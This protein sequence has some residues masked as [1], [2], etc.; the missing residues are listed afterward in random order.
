MA[1]LSTLQ[2]QLTEAEA[3]YHRLRIGSQVEEIEHSDMRTRYTRS[4]IGDLSAY[5]DNLK[6]QIAV[7]GGTV[8][9]TRRRSF[10]VDL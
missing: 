6:A 7:L 10:E 5:I 8:T 3:A 4:T 1:D 9:G 2:T